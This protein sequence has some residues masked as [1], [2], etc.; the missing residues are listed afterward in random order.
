MYPVTDLT[1][2]PSPLQGEGRQMFAVMEKVK[3]S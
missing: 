1:L 2:G 3:L